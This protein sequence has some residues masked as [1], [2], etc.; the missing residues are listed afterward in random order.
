MDRKQVLSAV[1]D[2]GIE[3]IRL[4]FTDVLGR[5]KG[6]SLRCEE[7]DRALDEGIN[8]DG[9]SVEGF[10]RIEE[11]DL[12]AR[13]DPSTYL[14][15]PERFGGVKTATMI[16]D[17]LYPDGRPFECDP[18]YVLK[19][20]INKATELGFSNFYVGPELE[21][22]YFPSEREPQPLDAGGYF[23]I[24]PLDKSA[25]ARKETFVTL[26]SLGID[27]EITHHEVARSQHELDFKY[28]DALKMADI[29]QVV[30][31][32]VKEI[33]R[34]YGIFASFMPKPIFGQNGS[35][36]HIHQ[37]LFRNNTNAFYDPDDSYNLSEVGKYYIAGLLRHSKEI[38]AVT[39]QWVNS[40]KRLVPG[41]EAPAY[42]CWGRKN[43]SA[44]VRVP[45]FK[46]HHSDSCRAEYRA[47]D[48][49]CNIYLA[50]AVMLAAGLDGIEK[51]Y[52]LPEPIEC[53][54]Y[55]KSRK[56]IDAKN[57]KCLPDSLY[58][59]TIE[60]E[61]SALARN[62]LGDALFEKYIANKHEEWERYRIQ[63]TDYELKEYLPTL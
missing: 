29:I 27:V 39:N 10:V 36:M 23:D 59:A 50:F 32:V 58:S 45:A 28:C 4:W 49:A 51:K 8:F 18:R 40:Y 17:I 48:P 47:P 54:L 26:R 22:F 62:T 19:N 13:P 38:T 1:K 9:S 57:I 24:L 21:Y 52:P 34:E 3:I 30:K 42:I 44:L 41:Y 20:M 11:S 53:D 14:V 5:L 6:F 46:P 43:R 61:N 33:A 15:L 35:G 60:M 12:L 2:S 63:V 56:E 31:V 7:L 37:S 16:C 25:F 55:T